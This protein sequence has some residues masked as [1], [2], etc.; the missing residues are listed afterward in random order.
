MCLGLGLMVRVTGEAWLAELR[1]VWTAGL[2]G[3]PPMQLVR[4]WVGELAT[5]MAWVAGLAL[6]VA[7]ATGVAGPVDTRAGEGLGVPRRLWSVGRGVLAVVVPALAVVLVIGVIAGAA[8]SASAS[9]SGLAGLW[10]AWVERLL[11]G[12]GCLLLAAGVADRAL[13]RR[14]LLR[15]LHRSVAEA[16]AERRA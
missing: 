3:A 16:R 15:A 6:G 2:A 12:T 7:V 5:L 4:W 8:R 1:E 14:R 11:F 13:A 9:A 10:T